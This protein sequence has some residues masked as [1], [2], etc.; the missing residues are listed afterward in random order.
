MVKGD[1]CAPAP[2]LLLARLRGNGLPF[3]LA[4]L[5][6]ALL[7]VAVL[8]LVIRL[9]RG[10]LVLLTARLRLWRR[11]G[12]RWLWFWRSNR[13][14]GSGLFCVSGGF[15]FRLSRR[16]RCYGS[17]A[18]SPLRRRG[19]SLHCL[20]LIVL[21]HYG[22]TRLVTIIPALQL[23]LLFHSGIPIP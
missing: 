16:L 20:P 22:L 18:L 2:R 11:A 23:L 3:L 13:W 7:L 19:R 21:P 6:F 8:F 15:G 1:T 5:V 14:P 10:R 9:A 4:V 12:L 17:S